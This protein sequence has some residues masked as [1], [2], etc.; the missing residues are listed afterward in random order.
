MKRVSVIGL[1][2]IGLPTA[3]LLSKHFRVTGVDT[4]ETVIKSINSGVPHIEEKDLLECLKKARAQHGFTVS[5]NITKSDIFIVTVP[6]PINEVNGDPDLSFVKSAIISISKVLQEGNLIIIESTCPPGTTERMRCEIQNIRPDL[7]EKNE[8]NEYIDKFHLAYCPE[9]VLPGKMLEELVM[10]DRVIGGTT[11]VSSEL[12]VKFYKKFILGTCI[13]ASNSTTAELCKLVENSFRDVNI[14]FANEL[15]IFCAKANI[16]VWELINLANRHPR[17]SILEPGPGVGGHCI[18]VDPWFLVN[19]DQ[20]TTKL[21]AGARKIN[22]E[23]PNFVLDQVIDLALRELDKKIICCGITF[24]PDIDDIRNSPSL[25][26][27]N[28]LEE[29]FGSRVWYSD[30]H[31]NLKNKQS[32]AVESIAESSDILVLLVDHLEFL[33][34]A[35]RSKNIIDTRGKWKI[36]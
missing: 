5:Q 18:A 9:R 25:L 14:A 4:D 21:I 16:D 8:D 6:T 28:K 15:S 27:F 26:I 36:D 32:F 29:M 20:A 3:A 17:V 23:K 30:P 31:V 1:G 11:P 13:I 7:T 34:I 33:Q 22:D 19:Y 24:K 2:Y 12:A 10:N 35:P